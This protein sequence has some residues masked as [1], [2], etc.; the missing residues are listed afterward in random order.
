MHERFGNDKKSVEQ[1]MDSNQA[2]RHCRSTY[3]IY[4]KTFGHIHPVMK[5]LRRKVMFYLP[6]AEIGKPFKTSDYL[7]Y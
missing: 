2:N 7:T 5:R 3:L 4:L 6:Y 1:Y